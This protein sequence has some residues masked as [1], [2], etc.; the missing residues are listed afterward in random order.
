[1]PGLVDCHLHAEQIWKAG[2]NYDKSF[3]EWII[4]DFF[5]TDLQFRMDPAYAKNVSSLIV[6]CN[7]YVT[8][9]T[10]LSFPM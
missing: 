4:Q 10:Y 2:A 8:G 1:M 5:P 6:V 7:I 3:L 9:N